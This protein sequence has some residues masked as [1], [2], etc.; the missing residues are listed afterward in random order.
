[1]TLSSYLQ[2]ARAPRER[3]FLFLTISNK[4]TKQSLLFAKKQ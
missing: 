4:T 2:A 3:F 1:M